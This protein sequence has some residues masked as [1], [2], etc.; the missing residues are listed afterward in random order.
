MTVKGHVIS[1]N[2]EALLE[3]VKT[4]Q[5]MPLDK[6]GLRVFPIIDEYPQNINFFYRLYAELRGDIAEL[7]YAREQAEKTD[8]EWENYIKMSLGLDGKDIKDNKD[9]ISNFLNKILPKKREKFEQDIKRLTPKVKALEEDLHPAVVWNG[10]KHL[11]PYLQKQNIKWDGIDS[12]CPGL[13]ELNI[14]QLLESYYDM[15]PVEETNPYYIS[16]QERLSNPKLL[17]QKKNGKKEIME[18]IGLGTKSVHSFKR[19]EVEYKMPVHRGPGIRPRV[20]A[21]TGELDRWK[22]RK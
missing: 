10:Y 6:N 22:N 5:L 2:G 9:V 7:D 13:R 4:G 12:L 18:Y 14:E 11:S 21:Y 17:G 20:F 15:P 1:P 8:Q 19:Y 16:E 3:H